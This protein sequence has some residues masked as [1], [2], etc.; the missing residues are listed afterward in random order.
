MAPYFFLLLLAALPALTFPAKASQ[1]YIV[2]SFVVLSLFIGLRYETGGD[3]WNYLSAVIKAHG[4]PF[5]QFYAAQNYEVLYALLNW[6]GAN[7]FGGLVFV[8]SIC[9]LIFAFSLVRFSRSQPYFWLALSVAIP[10]LVI[11][12][13]MG[14]TRQSVA[15]AF[16]MLAL[17]A[18]QSG[19]GLRFIILI[20]L[21]SLFHRPVLSLLILVVFSKQQLILTVPP[22][23]TRL[24]KLSLLSLVA[25]GLYSA[26]SSELATF[27]EG[28]QSDYSTYSPQ[29]AIIRVGL[30]AIFS[31]IFL[32]NVRSF[33][34]SDTEVEIWYGLALFG[35]LAPV[36]LSIGVLPTMIDRLALYLLPVQ[37]FV[38][39]RLP[40]TG[41]FGLRSVAWRTVLVS[42]AFT[43]LFVWLNFANNSP[44]WLPYRSLLLQGEF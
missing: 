1:V 22:R 44:V 42:F 38:G 11:V 8:N 14:Y 34:L 35:V 43:F 29:G 23:I 30:T 33:S 3:W 27:I 21:G 9:A 4:I 41:I 13:A 32:L 19:Q 6:I 20:L 17:L 26:N 39:A 25:L 7:L 16:E 5:N 31:S 24:F 10:Y 36:A 37:I 28:Y 2:T 12:V 18:L 40:V 15:I